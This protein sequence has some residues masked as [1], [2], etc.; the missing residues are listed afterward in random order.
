MYKALIPEIFCK[1]GKELMMIQR[2]REG[3]EGIKKWENLSIDQNQCRS[4]MHLLNVKA[5]SFFFSKLHYV[6]YIEKLK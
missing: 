3:R 5:E 4:I 6:T 2:I 1:R